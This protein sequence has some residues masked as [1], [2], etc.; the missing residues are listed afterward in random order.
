MSCVKICGPHQ[1][2]VRKGRPSDSSDVLA[3]AVLSFSNLLRRAQVVMLAFKRKR[4]TRSRKLARYTK[5]RTGPRL[6]NPTRSLRGVGFP[7]SMVVNV[8]YADQYT[9]SGSGASAGRQ[10][11]SLNNLHDPDVTGFG[12]QPIV[13]DQMSAIYSNFVVLG[14]RVDVSFSPSSVTTTGTP[15]GP[16]L[17]GITGNSSNAFATAATDLIE[18][19]RSVSDIVGRD[20][21]SSTKN[22][23]L[24]YSPKACLGLSASD[25]TVAG[26]TS[27][28]APSK[29]FYACVWSV[30]RSANSGSVQASVVVSYRVKFY[31][32]RNITGS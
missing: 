5:R 25:D 24:T 10:I 7:D 19:P 16:F 28:T 29:Q 2:S 27:G 31:N 6:G 22:L 30:D 3:L 32:L 1:T 23:T 18:Q 14:A 12:H 21:G 20:F 13:Y 8:R 11:M 9:L 17:V 26:T 15:F 4:T